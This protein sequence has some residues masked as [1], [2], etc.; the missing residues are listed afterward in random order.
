MAT[1]YNVQN[2][3]WY[4]GGVTTKAFSSALGDYVLSS[5]TTFQAWLAE[6]NVPTVI[7]TETSLGG[8]LSLSFVRPVH[9]VVLDGYQTVQATNI[10]TKAAFKIMFHH[11]NRLRVLES[12]AVI[13]PA[14]A[15]AAVKA[16][17]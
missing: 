10:L 6:G 7:D 14:Q 12:K 1:P 9:A 16:L 8:V 3:Y 4:V 13:T 11:E 5:D 15:L 2:W 17:M